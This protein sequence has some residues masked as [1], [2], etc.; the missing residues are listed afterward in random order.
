MSLFRQI[1]LTVAVSVLGIATLKEFKIIHGLDYRLADKSL[2]LLD[3]TLNTTQEQIVLKLLQNHADVC[4]KKEPML[5]E[6]A[7]AQLDL[8]VELC[9]SL[10][11]WSQVVDLYGAEPIVLGLD[12]CEAYRN[13]IQR[14]GQSPMPKVAALWNAGSTS[15]SRS[16]LLN[17]QLYDPTWHINRTTVPWGKHTPLWLKFINTY[18]EDNTDSKDHVLPIVIVRD[19]Y[20]WMNSMV[21]ETKKRECLRMQSK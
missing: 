7:A 3:P 5:R 12:T 16:F 13:H 6:L 20:R 17:L 15:L 2:Q 11:D 21:R 1:V 4:A 8:D 9:Y 14:D 18:P 19:P 10:P